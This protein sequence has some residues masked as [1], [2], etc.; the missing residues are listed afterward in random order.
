[1]SP[2]LVA[3]VLGLS[4]SAP[5]ESADAPTLRYDQFRKKI[6]FEAEERREAQI[7]GLQRLLELDP[8]PG[9]VPDLRFRLA[10]LYFETS[11]FYFF[12]SQELQG[13]ATLNNSTGEPELSPGD[14]ARLEELEAKRQ[15]WV[16]QALEEYQGIRRD[17]PRYT[18]LPE[19]LFALGQSYWNLGKFQESVDVYAEL[20][21]KHPDSP[22]ISE[23]WLAFGEFYFDQRDVNR[24]L[25]S[26][27]KAAEDRRSRVYGFALYKQAWCYYNRSEWRPALKKFRA[28]VLYSQVASELSGENKI[29]LGRE[30]QRDYVR[31]YQHVGSSAQASAAFAELL[32]VDSCTEGRCK[33]LLESLADLWMESGNFD[34]SAALYRQLI[35]MDTTD[36]RNILRQG[37]V[38]DLVSRGGSKRRV[39]AESKKLV[40]MMKELAGNASP[41]LRQEA[42]LVAEGTLRRLAQVWNKE[43]RKTRSKTTRGYALTMYEDYLALFPDS[44]A[45]YELRFQLADIYFKM[46]RFDAAATAYEKTV[47]AD[48]DGKYVVD[49]A[50]DNIL[51]VEEHLRDL[52][53]KPPSDT[54]DPQELHPQKRRL[55]EA[56][57]RYVKYVPPEKAEQLTIVKFKAAKVLYEYNRF[58]EAVARFEH[59]VKAH[60]DSDQ[61]EPAANLVIDVHNLKEDWQALYRSASAYLASS[62]LVE[63]RPKLRTD[64]QRYA[65]FAK[66]KLVQSLEKDVKDGRR[67]LNEVAKAYQEFYEE[68]PGSENAD[69]ALFNASVAWDKS[70]SKEQA[71]LLRQRLLE[72]YPNSPLRVDV[73]YYLARQHEERTEFLLAARGYA[74]FAKKYP[75]DERARDALYNA[76]AFYSGTGRVRTAAKLRLRYLEIYGKTSGAEAEGADIYWTVATELERSGR[77]K[78]AADR[79]KDFVKAYPRDERVWDA[80]WHEARLR[81]RMRQIGAARRLEGEIERRYRIASRRG[82]APASAR[83]WM[84]QLRLRELQDEYR[85]Y[86]NERVRAPS[87]RNPAP[88]QKSLRTKARMRD[89]LVRGYTDVVTEYSDAEAT[90]QALLRIAQA[91]DVFV[92]AVVGLPCPRGIPRDAC[93]LVQQSLNE[94]A[95]PARSAAVEAYRVCAQKSR[96]VRVYSDAAKTCVS[97]LEERGVTVARVE[98]VVPITLGRSIWM[99]PTRGPML[100][101]GDRP[102]PVAPDRVAEVSP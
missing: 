60:P 80:M 4:A 61:A 44:E 67:D 82:E 35:A 88:F 78:I 54:T 19:V 59:I 76:A 98:P 100:R 41:E 23:A 65:Q 18:R 72:E 5:A 46:E 77:I 69:K 86:R 42:E 55:L 90:V 29:A 73:A 24:A 51:A 27:Q 68:F 3:V 32:G 71:D 8:D 66:F 84:A 52:A 43:S 70:G 13:Q 85:D 30:A 37:K 47:L 7:A 6:E 22:L 2:A 81:T 93:E 96:E 95:A 12:R 97:T 14:R 87:L 10:E 39:I 83:R 94:T 1:M 40:A 25:K 31:T 16:Q 21:R 53:V 56:C 9:E 64:L 38:V 20:I 15:R 74:G 48:P 50:N 36:S 92:D 79:Y 57:D 89:G 75:Q 26:Y 33:K 49:A 45:A 63:R 62:Q 99:P 11:R 58:D 102:T 101:F 28:T 34:E 91:W 17:Y